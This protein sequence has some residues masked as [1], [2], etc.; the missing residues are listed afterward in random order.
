MRPSPARWSNNR[1][2][3]QTGVV[4]LLCLLFLTA[5]ALLGL[6][7]SAETV[8][9]EALAG[10]LQETQR[11]RQ[12][13]LAAQ[14]WAERWFL[15]LGGAAPVSCTR[16]CEGLLIHDAGSLPAHPESEDLAWWLT[17]AQVAGIDPFTGE[18]LAN[19][20]AT[21]NDL[22]LWLIEQLHLDAES[23]S[24]GAVDQA[25]YRIIARGGG[26]TP[27]SV[28]VVESIITR[29]WIP[30]A[31]MVGTTFAPEGPCPGFDPTILCRR[32]AW[33]ALR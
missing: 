32:V 2:A 17:N 18:R 23:E 19:L 33:R 8:M 25:W 7:A 3:A 1:P 30:T 11:A 27:A 5:L 26:P 31:S 21:S 10:N 15:G 12:S 9:Q 14:S 22:P 28:A 20:S 24:G 4:L 6:S 16:P 29:P 13:A